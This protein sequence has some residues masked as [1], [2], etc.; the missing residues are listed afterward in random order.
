MKQVE[1]K[2]PRNRGAVANIGRE[3]MMDLVK[4]FKTDQGIADQY[5]V[6]RQ[7]INLRRKQLKV[8]S[9]RANNPDRNRKMLDM[10]NNG[11][12]VADISK[13]FNVSISHTYR[14]LNSI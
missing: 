13:A 9:S 2:K 6:T 10:S 7:A 4:V 11:T 3:E 8:L 1:I 5:G 14:I 12:K